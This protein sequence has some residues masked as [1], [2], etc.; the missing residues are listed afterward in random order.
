MP[1][2]TEA[3]AVRLASRPANAIDWKAM[4]TIR[5]TVRAG[6][7]ALAGFHV[8]LLASQWAAGELADPGLILRWLT[9]AVLAAALVWTARRGGSLKSRRAVVIWLLAALLHAPAVAARTGGAI[10]LQTLPET[11]VTLVVQTTALAAAA[12]IAILLLFA[13]GLRRPAT[14]LADWRVRAVRVASAALSPGFV[15]VVGARPPPAR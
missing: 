2:S 7:A 1:I 11:A 12:A 14:R 15:L 4:R 8:W 9:A 10:D 6:G 3:A 13:G 5:W